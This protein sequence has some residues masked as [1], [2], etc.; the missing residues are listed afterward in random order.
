[1]V[2]GL[3]TECKVKGLSF[4]FNWNIYQRL[5]LKAFNVWFNHVITVSGELQNF[6]EEE[7]IFM[8]ST[9]TVQAAVA[10]LTP[11]S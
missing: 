3:K 7:D 5:T 1:M 10:F 8:A 9:G 2:R 4:S 6:L 11:G